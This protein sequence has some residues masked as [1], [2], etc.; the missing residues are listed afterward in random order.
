MRGNLYRE[1][2]RKRLAGRDP[3]VEVTVLTVADCPN[4][5]LIEDHLAQA[6]AGRDGVEVIRREIGSDAD[7]VRFGMR[8]SPTLLI[9]GTDP[10]AAAVDPFSVS[11]RIYR[12]EAGVLDGA[13]SVAALRRA[14]QEAEDRALAPPAPTERQSGVV[15]TE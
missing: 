6:L 11:C 1:E 10:F 3:V 15:E 9:N 12:T 5:P 2:E 7:A 14:F 8:G 4:G 13:P